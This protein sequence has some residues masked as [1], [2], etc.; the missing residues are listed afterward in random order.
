[1]TASAWTQDRIERLKIL[2]REGKTAEYIA[3]ELAHGISR[4]AVLGKVYRMGLSAGRAA[5]PPT[6]KPRPARALTSRAPTLPAPSPQEGPADDCPEPPETGRASLL[7]VRRHD[8]R[9]PLGDPGSRSFSLC[10]RPAVRGAYCAP[11]AQI[12]YRP[13]LETTRSL[14]RLA[15]LV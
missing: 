6:M 15:G 14:E 12:A 4:S 13:A 11:H 2:W 7:T 9:W 8:C 1:M 3:H 5:A 10:G